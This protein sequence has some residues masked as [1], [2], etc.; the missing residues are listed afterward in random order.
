ME[1]M[2]SNVNENN[3]V[4]DDV[5]LYSID[6]IVDIT[7]LSRTTIYRMMD[8]GNFPKS[9]KIG[10]YTVRWKSSEIRSWI[11]SLKSS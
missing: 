4:S 7:G 9:I 2:G 6:D 11:E 5:K 3:N 10:K 8:E 1:D